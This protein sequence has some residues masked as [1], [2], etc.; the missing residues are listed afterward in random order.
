MRRAVLGSA[1][2]AACAMA[3][4]AARRHS[5]SFFGF[6]VPCDTAHAAGRGAG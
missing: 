2:L 3:A 6:G 5:W 1:E 4:R